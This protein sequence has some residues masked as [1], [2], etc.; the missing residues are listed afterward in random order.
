MPG[1]YG[2]AVR[3]GSSGSRGGV[4]RLGL[5]Q[6]VWRVPGRGGLRAL[7]GRLCRVQLGSGV[8]ERALVV[9]GRSRPDL[10]LPRAEHFNLALHTAQ[11][12]GLLVHDCTCDPPSRE[13]QGS[14]AAHREK[15]RYLLLVS[16]VGTLLRRDAQ[17]GEPW[18]SAALAG[19]AAERR[20]LQQVTAA[21]VLAAVAAVARQQT[22]RVCVHAKR[23][24]N[25]L[26][27]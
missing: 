17:A 23:R 1:L 18:G 9:F 12:D 6:Q 5:R 4:S 7:E 13:P 20:R 21:A 16:I 11:L 27:V 26:F 15:R 8:E 10:L 19:R 24:P 22:A 2:R 14:R 3:I 25:V